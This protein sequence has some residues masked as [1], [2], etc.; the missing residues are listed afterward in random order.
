MGIDGLAFRDDLEQKDRKG[1]GRTAKAKARTREKERQKILGSRD[2]EARLRE[3]R[4]TDR[5]MEDAIRVTQDRLEVLKGVMERKR[6]GRKSS[7]G[8]EKGSN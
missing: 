7:G 1:S 4:M 8:A 5:E 2:T 3:E 6:A